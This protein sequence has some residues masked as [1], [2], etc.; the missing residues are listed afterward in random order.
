MTKSLETGMTRF[1]AILPPRRRL[2]FPFSSLGCLVLGVVFTPFCALSKAPSPV[3]R[4]PGVVQS[5]ALGPC[6]EHAYECA[7]QPRVTVER[8][9]P[10]ELNRI[11]QAQAEVAK[12]QAAEK[13][14]RDE[15]IQAHG[16]YLLPDMMQGALMMSGMRVSDDV[17]WRGDYL[18]L[19][20][21]WLPEL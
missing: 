21:E 6:A 15:I 13:S 4:A 17:E 9:T 16:G 14:T 7:G 19:T 18:I 2:A 3:Q 1:V 8:L 20:K 10:A 11:A 5:G 12:A